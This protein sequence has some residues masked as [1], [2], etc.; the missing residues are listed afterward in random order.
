MGN[1]PRPWWAG[2][3]SMV[4]SRKFWLAVATVA[5]DVLTNGW[6][7]DTLQRAMIVAGVLA[8]LI[9]AEDAASKLRR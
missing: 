5:A 9:T 2:L 4:S 1:E 3:W 7:Q 6:T 8:G